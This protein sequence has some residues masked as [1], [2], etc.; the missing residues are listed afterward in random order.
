M[1]IDTRHFGSIDITEDKVLTFEQG[2][3]GF[4]QLK[5]F[6]I[7]YDTKQNSSADV[8]WL[9]SLDEPAMALPVIDPFLVK[10][11]YKVEIGD[12]RL[13]LL[14]PLKAEAVSV[15][16]TLAVPQ[17][18]TKMSVNLCAP[19]VIH[20]EKKTGAQIVLDNNNYPV[21]YYIYDILQQKKAKKGVD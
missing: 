11:D 8:A 9:Q 10:E 15:L 14:G 19:I 2:L 4:E 1:R 18:I 12:E 21:K 6:A 5:K 13:Q 7:L 16:V 20:T 17:D 3:I